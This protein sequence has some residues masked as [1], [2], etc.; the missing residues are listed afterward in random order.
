[1]M[2]SML[3][4]YHKINKTTSIRKLLVGYYNI[5]VYIIYIGS[6]N[7]PCRVDVTVARKM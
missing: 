7:V 4:H 3:F 6:Q 5:E 2:K 1:M